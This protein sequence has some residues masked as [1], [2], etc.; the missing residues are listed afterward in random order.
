LVK[1]KPDVKEDVIAKA[2]VRLWRSSVSHFTRY[3]GRYQP[4]GELSITQSHICF[5]A[6]SKLVLYVLI[7][8]FSFIMII[9]SFILGY[10]VYSGN[11]G[12]NQIIP[13]YFIIFSLLIIPFIFS[14]KYH[15]K[16]YGGMIWKRNNIEIDLTE[17]EIKIKDGRNFTVFRMLEGSGNVIRVLS[18]KSVVFRLSDLS[19]LDYHEKLG[20]LEE[21]YKSGKIPKDLY[22][23]LK[24]K[25]PYT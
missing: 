16:L 10:W 9:F 14:M 19:G 13:F 23:E 24:R 15:N 5:K 12:N 2:S 3:P 1:N 6:K 4:Y 8:F 21:R 22:E 20:I 7:S 11:H 17:K 18:S 25:I